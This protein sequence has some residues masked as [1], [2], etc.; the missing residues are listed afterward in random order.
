MGK[1]INST[2]LYIQILVLINKGLT[3]GEIA[4]E[5]K[6]TEYEVVRILNY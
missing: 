5:L 2:P 6:I 4:K 3:T 1:E